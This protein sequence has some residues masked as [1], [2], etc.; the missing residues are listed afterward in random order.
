MADC[1]STTPRRNFFY[2]HRFAAL[3][4]IGIAVGILGSTAINIGIAA[5]NT[6]EFCISC[7]EMKNTVYEE[8]KTTTHFA[9][10]S[11]VSVT[12]AD[13]HV[14]REGLAKLWRKIEAS[15]DIYHTLIGTVD[16][17]AKFE[18]KR[19]E[20]AQRVWAYMKA[21]DSRECRSCHSFSAMVT[22]QQKP[23]ARAQHQSASTTGET[24]IDCHKGIA[25]KP[26]HQRT[27]DVTKTED[28]MLN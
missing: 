18:A 21:S 23:R 17:P 2:R 7:H 5:T 12:C 4:I 13:C 27:S 19:L 26:I 11:G 1:D 22:E 16:T 9:N 3:L 15:N 10:R 20:L 28:F 6:T 14:P 25:H 24:C 8:Y